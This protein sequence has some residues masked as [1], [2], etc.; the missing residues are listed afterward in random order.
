MVVSGDVNNQPGIGRILDSEVGLEA[1]YNFAITPWL[2]VTADFQ[3][4][5]PG[6]AATDDA[7]VLGTRI[8]VMF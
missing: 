7:F 6:I 1:Y 8:F 5:D 4:V 3:W 2:Q